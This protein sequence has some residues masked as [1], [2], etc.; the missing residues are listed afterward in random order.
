MVVL[1]YK[2][3]NCNIICNSICFAHNFINWTSGNNYIDKF[4]QD[5]QLL[6]HNSSYEVFKKVVEWIP[7]DRLYD[8]K[9][10]RKD[11]YDNIYKARWIDGYIYRWNYEH[12]YWERDG[13]N[14]VV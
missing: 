7:Y 11:L 2:C 6:V 13:K 9:C 8:I 14:I 10:I 1:E 5:I 3:K 12:Q 4:I